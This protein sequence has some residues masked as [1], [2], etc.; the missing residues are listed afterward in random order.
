MGTATILNGTITAGVWEGIMAAP[1]DNADLQAT[2]EGVALDGL[3]VTPA[4]SDGL[5]H[6]RLPLPATLINDGVQTVLITDQD[7]TVIGRIAIL[8]GAVLA[9]DL[10]AEIAL[11]RAELDMLKQ[12]FRQQCAKS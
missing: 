5:L 8:A 12:S 11:L 2:H 4:P 6:L 10:Q 1:D 7:G 3:T 9:E